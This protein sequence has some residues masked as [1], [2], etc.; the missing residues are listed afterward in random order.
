MEPTERGKEEEKENILCLR[1]CFKGHLSSTTLFSMHDF[2][3]IAEQL[4]KISSH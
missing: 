2:E 1:I 4:V 3:V